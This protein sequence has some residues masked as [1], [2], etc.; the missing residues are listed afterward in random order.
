LRAPAGPRRRPPRG[1][2]DPVTAR[3]YEPPCLYVTDPHPCT[4]AFEDVQ[5]FPGSELFDLEC[6]VGVVYGA[7]GRH[8]S[9]QD[10]AAVIVGS[11]IFDDW[12]KLAE[13]LAD[14][15]RPESRGPHRLQ[16]R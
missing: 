10:A 14:A 5:R 11:T 1:A 2:A 9:H 6:E 7:H 12:S 4:G 16:V 13:V 3:W 8:L 15:N